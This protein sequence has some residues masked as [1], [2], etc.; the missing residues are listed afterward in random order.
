MSPSRVLAALVL[1]CC[2]GLAQ[3]DPKA[4]VFAA[5]DAM[6]A[7]RAYRATIEISA[8]DQSFHQTVEMVIPDR[9]R[10]IGGPGGDVIVNP[11]GMWM[12]L[13]GAEWTLA[14]E[15]TA[16]LSR[17][18]MSAAFIEEAKNGVRSV[19]ALPPET[20]DGK[21]ARVYRVEQTMTIVGVESTSITKLYV[22]VASGRPVRQEIEARAMGQ[23]SRTVQT[24][25]YV[26]DLQIL[27]PR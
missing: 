8:N 17:H 19:T 10:M 24:L 5:W 25:E 23:S 12:K 14:P 7:A 13:P 20:V 26:A 27:A 22:D 6:V 18:N 3:A 15:A 2:A 1:L 16:A 11:E 4:E 21:Q 9:M